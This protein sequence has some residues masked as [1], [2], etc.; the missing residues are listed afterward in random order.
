MKQNKKNGNFF[1]FILPYLLII[2][3]IVALLVSF[4]GFY[5]EK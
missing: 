4:G 3:V 5:R 2:V 1:S